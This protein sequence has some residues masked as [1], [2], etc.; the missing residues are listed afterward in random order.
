M[1]VF[2]SFAKNVVS[3]RAVSLWLGTPS[4]RGVR[5]AA[6]PW[7]SRR[8]ACHTCRRH[9][10]LIQTLIDV[11]TVAVLRKRWLARTMSIQRCTH[12]CCRNAAKTAWPP[13]RHFAPIDSMDVAVQSGAG[14]P[15][16]M[17]GFVCCGCDE[18]V[19]SDRLGHVDDRLAVATGG[20]AHVRSA[21][22]HRPTR[23]TS[24]SST[25]WPKSAATCS[26]SSP[27]R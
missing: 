22:R 10:C 8:P 16:D 3:R 26:K 2:P 5:D 19:R 9:D 17:W 15:A 27:S 14:R 12:A 18:H 23:S 20:R 1:W 11:E 25:R 24:P 21:D 7:S 4:T 13:A 6:T